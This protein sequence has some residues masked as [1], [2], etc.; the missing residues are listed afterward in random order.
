MA[1]YIALLRGINVGGNH[2]VE[3]PRLK[4]L[5]LSMGTPFPLNCLFQIIVVRL[6]SR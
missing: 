1:R 3:M 2:K 4:A 5:L 6:N